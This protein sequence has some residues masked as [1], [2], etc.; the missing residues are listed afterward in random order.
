[1]NLL[2]VK[3]SPLPNKAL[4]GR[5]S[6]KP[7][8]YTDCYTILVDGPV[9]L[10]SYVNAFYTTWIFKCERFLLK[11]LVNRPSTDEDV[12]RLAS[13]ELQEFAAWSLE[14]VSPDEILLCDMA[15]RTRSWLKVDKQPDNQTK[16]FF[17]SAV[18]P[19]ATNDEGKPGLGF[20]FSALLGFH[21]VYSR[22]LLGSAVSRLNTEIL[23]KTA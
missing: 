12:S 18:V 16:L 11:W 7:G 5:Y 22:V 20:M 14:A 10:A 6:E 23:H 15:G 3:P 2:R 4:L 1:M 9:D 17:G 13:G 8:H 21:K 19:K